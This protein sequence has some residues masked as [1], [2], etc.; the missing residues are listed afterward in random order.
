MTRNGIPYTF[1]NLGNT[2]PRYRGVLTDV[3]RPPVRTEFL[4]RNGL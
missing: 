3:S 1:A 2:D 4:V